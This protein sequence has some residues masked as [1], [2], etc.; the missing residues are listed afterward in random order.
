MLARTR[1]LTWGA[2]AE[3]A[4]R[5][6]P[7]DGLLSAPDVLAT[8]A[9]TI[10][11]DPAAVWPWL[12]Q[13]GP[14]RGGAY[15]Y[16]WIENLLGLDM[17]SAESILPQ[18]QNL[19][20]GQTLPLGSS[21]PALRVAIADAPHALVFASLDHRWVWAFGLYPVA[22][23]TRLVSRNRIA[24]PH[25]SGPSRFVYTS[26]MEPGSLVMERKMLLGIKERAERKRELAVTNGPG[27]RSESPYS[28]GG[29]ARTLEV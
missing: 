7:G 15:T 22:G 6:M 20:V 1:C 14:G 12:V 11:A 23:G 27:A 2:T 17:H 18:Y 8:R 26:I 13:I 25:L 9:V 21:G 16:D 5:A 28:P 29:A 10:A 3:E 19:S 4:A 24:L